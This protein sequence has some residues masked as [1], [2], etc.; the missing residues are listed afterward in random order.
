[1]KSNSMI[2]RGLARRIVSITLGL[3]LLSSCASG[4]RKK[5]VSELF[6]DHWKTEYQKVQVVQITEVKEGIYR[7]NGI[8]DGHPVEEFYTQ[9]TFQFSKLSPSNGAAVGATVT[10]SSDSA[11]QRVYY[12]SELGALALALAKKVPASSRIAVLRFPSETKAQ[13]ALGRDIALKMELELVNQG[14]K[15][16]DRST[17]D[18]VLEEHRFQQKE[19]PLF[20]TETV[21]KIGKLVG[22]SVVVLG[23]YTVFKTEKLEINARA[24]EV[25]TAQVMSAQERE[26]PLDGPGSVNRD[27]VLKLHQSVQN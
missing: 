17:I 6:E 8:V 5:T 21:A 11:N 20:D 25:D 16:V 26:I 14:W 3:L 2:N 13:T 19:G 4:A 9:S 10:G 7:G 1:M 23:S 27:Q 18:Q 24:I 15:I 12:K 22:A